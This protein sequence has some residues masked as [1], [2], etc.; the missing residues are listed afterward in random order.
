MAPCTDQ[1]KAD[2]PH[3]PGYNLVPAETLQGRKSHSSHVGLLCGD[4]LGREEKCRNW[5]LGLR[6][7]FGIFSGF[8]FMFSKLYNSQHSHLP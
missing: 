4:Y 7:N 1:P 6:G 2:T 3:Y 5:L 8:Y